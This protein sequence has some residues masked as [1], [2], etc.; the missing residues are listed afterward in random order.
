MAFIF[1]DYKFGTY[2]ICDSFF[3]HKLFSYKQLILLHIQYGIIVC[4]VSKYL[5]QD[6]AV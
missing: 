6:R 1:L 3:H 5:M 4:Y 2:E